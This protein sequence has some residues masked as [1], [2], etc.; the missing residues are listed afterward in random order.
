MYILTWTLGWHQDKEAH[1]LSS[2]LVCNKNLGIYCCPI[3]TAVSNRD[4]R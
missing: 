1:G 3:L 4:K 2:S